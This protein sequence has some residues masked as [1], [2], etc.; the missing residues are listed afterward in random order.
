MLHMKL[1]KHTYY[2]LFIFSFFVAGQT[3]L[4]QADMQKKLEAKRKALQE[5]IQQINKRLSVVKKDE[6]GALSEY[7]AIK[8][9][10]EVRRKL[11]K[12]LQK[13]INHINYLIKKN[14]RK[15][16][17]LN[18]ELEKLKAD[19]ARMIRQSYNSRSRNDKLYF[20]FSSESFQQAF[21]RMQYMK[22]YAKYR[23]KQAGE[24]EKKKQELADIKQKLEADKKAKQK[25]Y[26]DYKKENE[27]IR[28]EQEK[29]LAVLNRIKSQKRKYLAQIKA[30]QR[31]QARIDKLIEEMIKKAINKSN[32]KVARNKRTKGKF[33]LTPEGK[34]LAGEFSKNKG[35]LPWPVKKAY[36]S[37]KFGVQP[38]EIF[39]NVK[40]TNA[41]I[42]LATEPGSKARAVF[43][44]KVLQIQ[45]IPGGNNTVFIRHGNYLTI[46]GNLKEVYVKPGQKVK[47]KQEIGKIATGP[48]G[49]TE[50]KFRI[51]KNTTKLNPELWL[52]KK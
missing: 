26:A 33:F 32:S 7:N 15:T 46:Y 36:I 41:G 12:N 18:K 24:I 4:A 34:K 19:Y 28:R 8:R 5:E 45:L 50:L 16:E 29:Q 44:G 27:I 14:T 6:S 48:N 3:A 37:R 42:Y 22:Q 9:K 2:L 13:E 11:I 23:K 35:Y 51:Y 43:D 52:M 30:K 39:K 20:L 1:I 17:E 31:E 47:M 38:H 49:K 21:K 10:I 40:V 25:L